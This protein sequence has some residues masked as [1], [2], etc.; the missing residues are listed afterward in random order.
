MKSEKKIKS[1][2]LTVG[3]LLV[4][5]ILMLTLNAGAVGRKGSSNSVNVNPISAEKK[6]LSQDI[7]NINP[8]QGKKIISA[9]PN[10]EIPDDTGSSNDM[11]GIS[12]SSRETT[13]QTGGKPKLHRVYL[14]Q[15]KVIQTHMVHLQ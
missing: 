1:H 10:S 7:S 2:F 13:G 3:I 14:Y 9:S 5:A 15:V 6:T 11:S 8:I 4:L 12:Q